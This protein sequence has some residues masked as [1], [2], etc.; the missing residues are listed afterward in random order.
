[1]ES[2]VCSASGTVPIEVILEKVKEEEESADNSHDKVKKI[3]PAKKLKPEDL[4]TGENPKEEVD[5]ELEQNIKVDKK[6]NIDEVKVMENPKVKKIEEIDLNI[7]LPET[8]RSGRMIKPKKF[9]EDTQKE[10][11]RR[12]R[13]RPAKNLLESSEESRGVSR[14]KRYIQTWLSLVK[15]FICHKEPAKGTQ[16]PLQGAFGRN[17]ST[18]AFL[19]FR[20]FFMA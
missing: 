8:S 12:P 4:K 20:W 1:M 16:S 2:H 15:S 9:F 17:A 14:R 18:R 7:V 19:A 11:K 13:K 10:E 5:E 3:K 6:I